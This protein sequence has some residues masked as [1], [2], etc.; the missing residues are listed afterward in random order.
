MDFK[1]FPLADVGTSIQLVG[2][3]WASEKEA[4][5]FYFPEYGSTYEEI[6][7]MGISKDDWKA[8]LRQSDLLE[9]EVL[10]KC[11]D[12]KLYKAVV[13]K[14]Q[15]NIDQQISWNVFRRDSYACRYCGRDNVPLTVDHLVL[16]ED[17]GPSTEANLVSACKKCNKTRGNTKYGDWL[18]SRYYRKVS[19]DLTAD[20]KQ[21]NDSI[22]A[23]LDIIELVINVRKKR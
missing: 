5:L 17:G 11:E 8:L 4:H 22:T 6:H 16:W 12:G 14:C 2:G 3:I 7:A 1:D 20:Q 19:K 9:T 10:S 23:T 21:A 15:R 13:R 18:N